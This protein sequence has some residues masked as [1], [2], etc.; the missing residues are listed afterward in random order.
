MLQSTYDAQ[1]EDEEW[2]SLSH[3]VNLVKRQVTG[4]DGSRFDRDME[5]GAYFSVLQRNNLILDERGVNEVPYLLVNFRK[6]E[7]LSYE[8]IAAEI[9]RGLNQKYKGCL[10]N[11]GICNQKQTSEVF[12]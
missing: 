6:Q 8:G 1:Y 4:L 3:I 10:P 7:D 2:V 5:S 11:S 9:E 12:S